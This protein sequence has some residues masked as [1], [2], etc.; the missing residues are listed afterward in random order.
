MSIQD[1]FKINIR[2][3]DFLMFQFIIFIYLFI[4]FFF[5]NLFFSN[6]ND[7]QDLERSCLCLGFFFEQ[8]HFRQINLDLT[9]SYRMLHIHII[10][11]KKY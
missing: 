8:Y 7:A 6:S 10:F 11:L 5:F 3:L 4:S 9:I 2:C 1:Q